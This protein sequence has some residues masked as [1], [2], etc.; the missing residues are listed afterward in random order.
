MDR[1]LDW[2]SGHDPR[3]TGYRFYG[4]VEK[5]DLKPPQPKFWQPGEILNQ[6][7]E[8]ACVGFGWTAELLAT[9]FGYAS[10]VGKEYESFAHS[11]YQKAR[12]HDKALGWNWASGASVIGGAR[13]I[14]ELGF[15][16]EFRWAMSM[17]E[18]RDAVINEGP[19][20]IGIPWLE[21]MYQTRP[22]GLVEVS[23]R[24]VGGHCLTITGYH[25]NM[26]IAGEGASKRFEVFRWV[27]SW[28]ADYGRHGTGLI[29][30]DK[31]AWL[32]KG[33][34]EA[35]IPMQRRAIKSLKG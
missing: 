34:G 19:V 35:C 17:E 23:G 30:M 14:R 20:V 21:G 18:L 31:L 28:G 13:T 15:I 5:R 8:G 25:P 4:A 7:K 2:C 6:G 32:L 22:S 9:P 10:K 12:A 27:N 26:R 29:E 3:S 33:R 24:E 1:V 16:R 11:V